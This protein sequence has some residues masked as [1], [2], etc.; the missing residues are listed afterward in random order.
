MARA[1]ATKLYRTFVKG[2]I[3]EA[4]PLTYPEDATIAESNMTLYR[5]G[6]RSRRLGIGLESVDRASF[7]TTSTN[8][9]V[10]EYRWDSVNNDANKTF[11]VM[12]LGLSLF[13]FDANVEPLVNGQKSFSVDLTPYVVAGTVNPQNYIVSMASGRGIL[14]VAGEIIEPVEV[15]YNDT[16]DTIAS[17]RIYVQIRDFKGLA[18]GL[19]N[20]EEPI[21]LTPEHQYNLLNQGWFDPDGNGTGSMVTYF[22]RF[23]NIGTYNQ[24]AST[25]ITAYYS[26]ANRYPGNNKQ[27]WTAKTSS[28]SFSPQ[29]LQKL[30]AGTT[31][32][33]RGHYI[34]DAFNIDRTAV[35]GVIGL[36]IESSKT[37]PAAISFANGRLWYVH[38]GSVYFSQVVDDKSKA[39]FCYQEADPT[40]E[41]I[42]DLIATDGG[43]IPIP[44]MAKGVRL[45]PIGSGMV[46]FATNG[47]WFI[48]GTTAGFTASD[49][50]VS[51]VSPIG[52]ES[53]MS[54][55]AVEGNIYWWSNIGIMAMSENMGMFGAVD[56]K[57]ERANISESTIQTLFNDIPETH[58]RTVKAVYDPVTNVIQWLFRSTE[59]T[60]PFVYDQIL[61]LDLTLQ[62]FYP[63][64]LSRVQDVT[65][66]VV[67]AITTPVLSGY[68]GSFE[69]SVKNTEIRYLALVKDGS[70]YRMAAAQFNDINFADWGNRPFESFLETGYELMADAARKKQTPWVTTFFKRTEENYVLDGLDYNTNRQSSCYFQV[71]WDWAS[72]SVSNKYSTKRQAYRHVRVPNFSVDNLDFDTGFPIVAT[73]HK[74]RGSGRAI[75]FRFD[76]DEIGKDFDLLGWQ[77]LISGNTKP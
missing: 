66:D 61:N 72:S 28:G 5:T 47:V 41:D 68:K 42:S 53:P 34:V 11:I 77:V 33:P 2:L 38:N 25:P 37:R 27:W 46:V 32:A 73:K 14:Y 9:A 55:I 60:R 64:K 16:F 21:T 74:V 49:F 30:Y 35:S 26:H 45:I 56:G 10:T 63:W 69:T 43:V 62:S 51:K 12:Q 1:E 59:I 40:A 71:K 75:Q 3:T 39:G 6:N 52:T 18:D 36:P 57:F 70:I 29:D 19:A 4:G 54:I 7:N 31:L 13:F 15:T 44:E 76:T 24:Q 58:R 8:V 17:R 48:G 20:D 65:P 23:G 67:G 22:D 50:S